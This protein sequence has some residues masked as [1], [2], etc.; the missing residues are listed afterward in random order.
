[1]YVHVRLRTNDLRKKEL[2]KWQFD[3]QI[4]VQSLSK[5]STYKNDKIDLNSSA[6]IE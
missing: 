4:L 2:G 3:K 1:M 5:Y 6:Y